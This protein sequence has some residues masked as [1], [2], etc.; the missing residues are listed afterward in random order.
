MNIAVPQLYEAILERVR[1]L[2][3]ENE[4]TQAEIGKALGIKQSAVSYLLKGKTKLTLEQFLTLSNLTGEAPNRLILEADSTLVEDKPMPRA[5]EEL[6][7]KSVAHLFCYSASC[8]PLKPQDLVTSFMPLEVVTN[9]LNDMVRA[10]VIIY[11]DGYYQQ[12]DIH[13]NYVA[14]TKSGRDMRYRLHGEVHRL[15]QQIH[16]RQSENK[17]YLAKRF[18][19]F[20][21]GYFTASQI[22][23]IEESL[24]RAYEKIKLAQRENMARAYKPAEEPLTLWQTHMM[25]MT[26]L[27]EK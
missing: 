22:R 21:L 23:S 24:W 20:M 6:A 3:A 18:N 11:K 15:C 13:V 8:V 26:P 27:E 17:E 9:A 2:I 7:L 14:Q 25:L 5:M 10:G 4:L 16:Q 1:K 12:R 19:Y